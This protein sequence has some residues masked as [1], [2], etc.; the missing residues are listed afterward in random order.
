MYAYVCVCVCVPT[1]T[2]TYS[3]FTLLYSA[4]LCYRLYSALLCF[5]VLCVPTHMRVT[6]HVN[7]A[8]GSQFTRFT[9]TKVPILTHM[10]VTTHMSPQLQ[11]QAL[12]GLPSCSRCTQPT[13]AGR[14]MAWGSVPLRLKR[15][16]ARALFSCKSPPENKRR[17]YADVC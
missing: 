6:T 16:R 4:L 2:Q 10:R 13:P 12:L 14:R 8:D 5:T 15:Q 7:N 17:T 9:S 1:H 3:G 11:A